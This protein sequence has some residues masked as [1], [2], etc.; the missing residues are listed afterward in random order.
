MT[1]ELHQLTTELVPTVVMVVDAV[2]V[3]CKVP[4]TAGVAASCPVQRSTTIECRD[5][6]DGVI[7]TVIA[8]GLPAIVAV[9]ITA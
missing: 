1:S 2:P 6:A 5:D 3:L 7:D 4:F 9:Q 8:P